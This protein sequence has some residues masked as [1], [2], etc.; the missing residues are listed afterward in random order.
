[1]K[2]KG[3]LIDAKQLLIDSSAIIEKEVDPR[4]LQE[5]KK[6]LL[7]FFNNTDA[8][9]TPSFSDESKNKL[10]HDNRTFFMVK[11]GGKILYKGC[12]YVSDYTESKNERIIKLFLKLRRM[13]T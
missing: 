8:Y 3:D 2:R 5:N 7:D 1:M 12:F 13:T 6:L 9:L 4:L 11:N 10:S